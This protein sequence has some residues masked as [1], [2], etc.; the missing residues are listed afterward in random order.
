[1]KKITGKVV[2]LVLALAL[3][4]TSFSANFAFAANK[5]V[6][7]T[8]SSTDRDEIYLV[9]G[10]GANDSIDDIATNV[11][12]PELDTK[13]H[14]DL[15]DDVEIA[16]ISHVSGD[17]LV[18]WEIDDDEGDA[19]LTVKSD[20]KTGKEVLSIL[21]EDTYN[22]DDGDTV[23]VKAR[24]NFT[25]YVLDEDSLVV[26]KTYTDVSERTGKELEAPATLAQTKGSE[27]Q[28]NVYKVTK[29]ADAEAV[30][31]AVKVTTTKE[32]ADVDAVKASLTL[33]SA[34][35]V[36][37]K[38]AGA[39][40]NDITV[41]ITEDGAAS[42][43]TATLTGNAIEVKGK[44]A[45]LTASAVKDAIDAEA[46][47]KV[48]TTVTEGE[49]D[50]LIVPAA[51]AN[52]ADGAD[53]D[54]DVALTAAAY[55][56]LSSTENVKIKEDLSA[57]DGSAAAIT[58]VSGKRNSA[59]ALT[60][61]AAVT[62][63]TI[64]VKKIDDG[65]V[66]K[67]SDDKYTLKTKVEKKVD[68]TQLL[69]NAGATP[70]GSENYT[71]SKDSGKIVISS[72]NYEPTTNVKDSEIVFATT[73]TVSV[74][75]GSVKKISGTVGSVSVNDDATVGSIDL[76]E[77]AVTVDGGKAGDITTDGTTGT[78]TVNSG[79]AGNIDTSDATADEV[80]IYA[81]TVGTIETDDGTVTIDSTDEDEAVSTGK[82]TAPTVDAFAEDA[83]VSINGIKASDD[84]TFTFKGTDLTLGTVDFDYRETNVVFGTDDDEF[85][86]TLTNPANAKNAKF[87]TENED[88]DV[89]VS[90]TIT[91]DSISVGSDS[92][93]TFDSNVTV[94]TIDG[95]GAM[96][97][98]AGK[99]Y[100]T[101]SVSS[102]TLK[103]SD[104]TLAPG[105]TVFKADSDTVD[106]DDF[107]TF[108]F[109]LD[110]STG[111]E[112]DTFKIKT[113]NFAGLAINKTSSKIA[114]GYSET[115]TASAYPTGTSLPVGA[116]IKWE[117]DG[118]SDD[119][120][121]LT[122]TGNTAKVDITGIDTDFASENTTT[123]TATLYDED[124]YELDDYDA[125]TCKITAIAVP[126]AT[127]DTTKDFSVAK[128]SAYQFKITSATAPTFTTGTAGVFSVALAS[129]NGNEYFYKITAIGNVGA[130][131]GIYLNG[132]KLL[133]ATVKA[134]AFTTDT[135]KDVTVKGAYTLKVTA[136]A[137]PTF[138][139]GTAGVFKAEFVSKTGND[140]LY[141]ITSVGAVGAKT[142]VYVN[143]VKTFVATVG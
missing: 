90:G 121:T 19:D 101:G 135:T 52:L 69:K 118:G 87:N 9:N 117:L 85:V 140:Y 20:T 80:T 37:A 49:E 83:K 61:D 23:T 24:K 109:T 54:D 73:G 84:G 82:I 60:N 25:V 142:G 134:P 7:G 92:Q 86:G 56:E 129:V 72:G 5:S 97:I 42:S 65:A 31:E 74:D 91:L 62:N 71:I 123:L 99:L 116:T 89:T 122:T 50:T 15:D 36:T 47:A 95:D 102:T 124:G 100:V 119:V 12:K 41:A 128:G 88:T 64:T 10:G 131:T 113:L 105:T 66:S 136:A 2:S 13:D 38:T 110:V 79:K 108:G 17:N 103:L 143:G 29:G 115:F 32:A 70:A 98:A 93:I 126:E 114:K 18:K 11:I 59:G 44:T 127:S 14:Q 111:N 137:T 106:E 3:V 27:R 76:D 130:S 58:L 33:N 67:E 46:S 40:G 21:Y 133:V 45:D 22:N 68:A 132:N 48:A 26:G 96:K 104:T 35:T 125:A 141:K 39:A 4:V 53:A 43:V 55:L 81:G 51:A 1:M 6:S 78:V 57:I 107:E 8:V 63:F 77:G 112:V 120:F 138:A 16:A 139:L 34:L 94:D 30:Y 75:E 28:I